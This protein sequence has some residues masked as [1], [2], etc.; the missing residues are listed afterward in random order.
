MGAN[1]AALS[2]SSLGC[3]R[4]ADFLQNVSERQILWSL[5]SVVFH[6][7]TLKS[8]IQTSLS[9]ASKLQVCVRSGEKC[10]KFRETSIPLGA[11]E[12]ALTKPSQRRDV[13]LYLVA[14]PLGGGHASILLRVKKMMA[15]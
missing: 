9:L 14:D 8:P 3:A 6:A 13:R 11:N 1:E 10:Q 5:C 4:F 7:L 15:I 2:K 12:T